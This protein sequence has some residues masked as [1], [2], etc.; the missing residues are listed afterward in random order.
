MCFPGSENY[1]G[2][3]NTTGELSISAL[4]ITDVTVD[5]VE[6]SLVDWVIT[7]GYPTAPN[8]LEEGDILILTAPTDGTETFIQ[9][10]G[11]AGTT[12]D[13]TLI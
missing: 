9:N 6:T 2:Y 11:T 10:G 13:F 1:L 8:N 3:D 12:A 5:T 7:S 4:A